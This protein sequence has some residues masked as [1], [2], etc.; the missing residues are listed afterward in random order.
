MGRRLRLPSPAMAVALLALFFALTATAI[1]ADVVPLA[2]RA[3]TADKAKVATN[4][5]KLNGKTAAQVAATP[6]PATDAATLNGQTAAQIASTPGPAGSIAAGAITYRSQSW[7]VSNEKGL[8]RDTAL[9]QAGEKV[10]GG[11]WD[12]ANGVVLT[13]RDQPLPDGSGW[14]VHMFAESGNDL[15]ASGTMWAVCLR[16][17]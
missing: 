17:S 2:K 13:V 9:C 12:Q 5:R 4:A 11:G 6:G 8:A 10:I 14:R 7:S 16:V 1:A 3:L 15:P